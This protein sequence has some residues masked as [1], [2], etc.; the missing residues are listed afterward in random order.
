MI[1]LIKNSLL[2]I[3]L[4]FGKPQPTDVTGTWS[5]HSVTAHRWEK[6]VRLIQSGGTVLGESWDRTSGVRGRIQAQVVSTNQVVGVETLSN[7]QSVD[8]RWMTQKTKM[9]GWI[10]H[11]TAPQEVRAVRLSE[12]IPVFQYL[13]RQG[14]TK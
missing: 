6:E 7:G 9:E 13:D 3:P 1:L 4:W 5:M 8:F 2:L 11:K 10:W 14:T 12:S